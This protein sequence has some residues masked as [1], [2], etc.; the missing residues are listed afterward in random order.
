MLNHIS[1]QHFLN[2]KHKDQDYFQSGQIGLITLLIMGVVLTIAISLSQRTVQEQQVATTQDESTR[3]FN[4]AEIGIERGLADIRIYE[5]TGG[6]LDTDEKNFN[7]EGEDGKYI[8]DDKSVFEM[9]VGQNR[10]TQLALDGSAGSATINWKGGLCNGPRPTAI[11]VSVY[12]DGGGSGP[13]SAV[14]YGYD[15]CPHLNPATNFTPAADSSVSGYDHRANITLYD[16]D[17]ILRV[18]PLYSSSEF[19]ISSN[20]FAGAAQYDVQSYG[21][22]AETARSIHVRKSRMSAPTYMD[23]SLISGHGS[24]TK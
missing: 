12:G 7:K 24:L 19:Q 6:S 16:N 15:P 10:T 5:E 23:F 22:A 14:H 1:Y 18:R 4:I 21:A 11:L 3:A 8:I 20:R 17:R 2:S 9:T 13:F